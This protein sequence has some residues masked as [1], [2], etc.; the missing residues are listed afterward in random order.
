LMKLATSLPSSEKWSPARITPKIISS[1]DKLIAMG[2]G[3]I[4]NSEW[5]SILQKIVL[6]AGSDSECQ[7]G[8]PDWDGQDGEFA[9]TISGH[10]RSLC[11]G[12][13]GG[14]L[15][16]P[17]S[18][19]KNEKFAGYLVGIGNLFVNLDNP[20]SITCGDGGRIANYFTRTAKYVDWIASVMGVNSS[21]LLATPETG[22]DNDLLDED[23]LSDES[24]A[25]FPMKRFD[26]TLRLITLCLLA[27]AVIAF[28][29]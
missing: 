25:S 20:E 28:N 2:W 22:S 23:D 26:D 19:N 3:L 16:L 14:P 21:E 17:T 12:D 24:A 7:S 6:T 8:H 4:E 29:N 15:V 11:Y 1:G 18:P 5:P 10:G 27:L 13:G 9:C